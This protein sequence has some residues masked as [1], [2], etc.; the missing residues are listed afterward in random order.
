MPPAMRKNATLARRR[1]I[2]KISRQPHYGGTVILVFGI[3]ML[4][5]SLLISC[6]ADSGHTVPATQVYVPN[7]FRMLS[8]L[9]SEDFPTVVTR[10][11]REDHILDFFRNETSRA[12][13]VEFFAALTG[14]QEISEIILAEASRQ[15]LSPALVFALAYHESRF[16]V[17]AVNRNSSSIDRGLF[18]LNSR[19]FPKL[20]IEEFF[21]PVLNA[22]LGMNHL[23]FCLEEGGNEVVAL[24]V[25]NAGLTRIRTGGTPL[26]TLNYI[27]KIIGYRNNVEA[28]FEAQVVAR[29]VNQTLLV[30]AD[31]LESGM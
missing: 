27:N 28:L 10:S 18:Q 17:R 4:A 22:R 12:A 26:S 16:K 31:P 2:F 23:R 9:S 19:T 8:S 11:I 13:T 30:K 3:A 15:N 7:Q 24:A 14:S 1:T 21:D 20:T 29:H 25:Y 5:S 6:Q